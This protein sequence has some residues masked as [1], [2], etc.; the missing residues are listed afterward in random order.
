MNIKVDLAVLQ[1]HCR[2]ILKTGPKDPI[3]DLKKDP[4]M[5]KKPRPT[6][7][8]E[9]KKGQLKNKFIKIG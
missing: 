7:P 3:K 6:G 5:A 4:I 9:V 2:Q 8:L 1:S